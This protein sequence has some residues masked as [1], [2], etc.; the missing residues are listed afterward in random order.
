ME[1]KKE[2]A[3]SGKPAARAVAKKIITPNMQ[4]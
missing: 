2:H 4:E 3:V 1:E